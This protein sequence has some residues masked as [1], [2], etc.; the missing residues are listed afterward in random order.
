MLQRD[1]D[2]SKPRFNTVTPYLHRIGIK[3]RKSRVKF[4]ITLKE[5]IYSAEYDICSGITWDESGRGFTTPQKWAEANM[6]KHTN[7]RTH[8]IS[9]RSLIRVSG[10]RL[11]D[12]EYG[13]SAKQIKE[14]YNVFWSAEMLAA[15]EPASEEDFTYLRLNDVELIKQALEWVMDHLVFFVCS[16]CS[17]FALIRCHTG[18]VRSCRCH[19]PRTY[20]TVQIS[21]RCAMPQFVGAHQLRGGDVPCRGSVPAHPHQ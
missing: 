5:K 21:L 6:R 1:V 18:S 11:N 8:K 2:A 3:T 16:E 14:L 17:S 9:A 19:H 4:E 13:M 12:F 15:I 7:N 10:I 20:H